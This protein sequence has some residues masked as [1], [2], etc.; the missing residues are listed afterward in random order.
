MITAAVSHGMSIASDPRLLDHLDE[1][2]VSLD[3]PNRETNDQLRGPGSYEGAVQAIH[4]AVERR[5]RTYVNMLLT[6]ASI[7]DLD[8]MLD[9]CESRSVK[10]HAQ[11]VMFKQRSVYG[12]YFD[13]TVE[14]LALSP[15]QIR[16]AHQKMADGKRNGRGLIF[17]ARAY[18]KAADWGNYSLS[19]VQK[20]GNSPCMAGRF[21][22]HI[23]PN[24]DVHPCG[25]NESEF[26]PK[27]IVVD[28]L[29]SAMRQARHH[30]CWDCWMVY[31]NERKI[32]F[33]LKPEALIEVIRRG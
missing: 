13:D 31:M 3:S 7:Q 11:P 14:K 24:G 10:M 9:Y 27:N 20:P 4:L 26:K 29:E 18:Q 30:N 32:V 8:A 15:D 16:A 21:Y 6:R 22:I 28:G 23:E 2:V 17:S 19:T 25:L 5:L 1:L 12:R 33:G